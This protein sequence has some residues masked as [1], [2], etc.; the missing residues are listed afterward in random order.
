MGE[1]VGQATVPGSQRRCIVGETLI[2]YLGH[3]LN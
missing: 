2:A 3:T 1:H